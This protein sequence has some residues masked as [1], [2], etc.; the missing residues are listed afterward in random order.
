M[1]VV[2]C[3]VRVVS[4]KSRCQAHTAGN[5]MVTLLVV[6]ASSA[7]VGK[8]APVLSAWLSAA[9]DTKYR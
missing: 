5:E 2:L 8:Y 3:R 7:L 1:P 9:V 4:E 6:C